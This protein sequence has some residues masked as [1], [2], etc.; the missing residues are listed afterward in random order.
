M[1]SVRPFRRQTAQPLHQAERGAQIEARRGL[2]QEQGVRPVDQGAGQEQAPLLTRRQAVEPALKQVAGTLTLRRS[3]GPTPL[4]AGQALVPVDADAGEETRAHDIQSG[5]PSVVSRLQLVRDNAELA[6][7]LEHV[8]TFPAEQPHPNTGPPQR[9]EL[10]VQHPQQG[11]L[12]GAVRTENSDVLPPCNVK[13]HTVEG[14]PAATH[15]RDVREF[16]QGFVHGARPAAVSGL[17]PD[18]RPYRPRNRGGRFSRNAR[19]PST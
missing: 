1:I 12:A 16:Q 7:D 11:R 14:A 4:R 10:T 6:P 17:R 8:P 19:R 5:Q 3:G 9:M 2:V 15:D 13:R 18:R